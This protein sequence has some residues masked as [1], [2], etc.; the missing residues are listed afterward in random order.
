MGIISKYNSF[1][2]NGLLALTMSLSVSNAFSEPINIKTENFNRVELSNFLKKNIKHK[3]LAYLL[4]QG[5]SFDNTRTKEIY[6]EINEKISKKFGTSK[7]ESLKKELEKELEKELSKISKKPVLIYYFWAIPNDVINFDKNKIEPESSLANSAM[8]TSETCEVIMKI[9][10]DDKGRFF[11]SSELMNSNIEDINNFSNEKLFKILKE[12]VQHEA[13]H[14]LLHQDLQDKNFEVSFSEE[15]KL[16]NPTI[17][18]SINN[19]IVNV[20]NKIANKEYSKLND[21]DFLMFY[22]YHENYADITSFFIELGEKPNQEKIEEVKIS[23]LDLLKFREINDIT[24]KTEGSIQY[25][26]EKIEEASK[27]PI[28]ERIKFAK[29][30]AGD[31]LLNNMQFIFKEK[32]NSH[33]EINIM[34]KFLVGGVRLENDNLYTS[35]PTEKFDT[36]NEIKKEYQQLMKS[37]QKVGGFSQKILSHAEIKEKYQENNF[38][39]N[40][41][42]VL[43]ELKENNIENTQSFKT[44]F[45][46]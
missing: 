23:L 42:K 7:I 20:K 39:I 16:K 5:N 3:D 37:N 27:M 25:S 46:L 34:A 31:S 6:N 11:E 32:A 19:I 21:L 40:I 18:K 9:G 45:K 43:E 10:V 17:S 35:I 28:E 15:F 36:Y 41:N 14:C 33:N 24:H 22:N 44:S 2:I 30:I 29:Q 8:D 12:T 26:L 1:L 38:S 4:E 13:S